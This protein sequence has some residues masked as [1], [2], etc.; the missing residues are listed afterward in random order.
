[1]KP[2]VTVILPYFEGQRWLKGAIQCVQAQ[3]GISWELIVVDDGSKQ[4]PVSIINSFNDKNIRL[5]SITHA[6]KGVALNKGIKAAW[7]DI[8]CFLDQ[9][10]VMM[11]GRLQLQ[12]DVFVRKPHSEVVYSDYER[13]SENG[14]LIDQFISY[15][16]SSQECL[17]KL[18]RDISPLSMQTI[19]IKKETIVNIGGF[20][21]DPNLTGL[22][23]AE[24]LF[25]LF[26][27]DPV[28]T[29]QPGFVQQWVEHGV[30]YSKSA[31][32]QENRLILLDYLSELGR[33]HPI[34][35]K[36]LPYIR[37]RIYYMRGLYYLENRAA[38]SAWPEF[39]RAIRL[40]PLS[41][42]CYYLL[43][44][45]LVYQLGY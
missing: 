14:K 41:W 7:A 36:E 44:K 9:D 3:K 1:M 25:R 23:D 29:Y 8:I 13:V 16:A 19:M 42:N 27:A 12:L 28:L 33:K 15:Q 26:L 34:M 24:F 32:F 30:N 43:I 6:G 4:S 20:C 17:R 31:Q 40:R 39:L 2:E 37:F 35:Q 38:K 45:S 5:I 21:G 11:P 10:D 22:D 18:A